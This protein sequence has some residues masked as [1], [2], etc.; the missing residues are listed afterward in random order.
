MPTL[1]SFAKNIA[2]R[3]LKFARDVQTEQTEGLLN[4]TE[5]YLN[6]GVPFDVLARCSE[7][8]SARSL[9]I[10][11][12]DAT[13]ARSKFMGLSRDCA[14]VAS[15]AA[16]LFAYGESNQGLDG[17]AEYFSAYAKN[18]LRIAE[19]DECCWG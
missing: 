2:V 9:S 18:Y 1:N 10:V 7:A 14:N 11:D 17:A 13:K 15:S 6:G 4:I 16:L 3:A 5:D 8:F 19:C 12:K